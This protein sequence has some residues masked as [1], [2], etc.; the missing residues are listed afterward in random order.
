MYNI[1][2][3]RRREKIGIFAIKNQIFDK[4]FENQEYLKS[5]IDGTLRG[6]SG[7][8]NT[9]SNI[10]ALS[11]NFGHAGTLTKC[12]VVHI[13]FDQIRPTSEVP[14]SAVTLTT[15]ADITR[16]E[17]FRPSTM[18]GYPGIYLT[19]RSR[20]ERVRQSCSVE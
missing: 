19:L 4:I 1:V 2:T 20:G 15:A 16:N 11:A 14:G 17:R 6:E 12:G 10:A 5:S 18:S 8:Q 9:I 3:R 7:R 13:D